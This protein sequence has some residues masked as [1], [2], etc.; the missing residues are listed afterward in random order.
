[1]T[2]QTSRFVSVLALSPLFF[3]CTG[4]H[5]LHHGQTV[6]GVVQ[7]GGQFA[8]SRSV[9]IPS[10]GLTLATAVN[11]NLR[12]WLTAQAAQPV[13]L[14]AR[15]QAETNTS[16]TPPLGQ[17]SLPPRKELIDFFESIREAARENADDPG[18]EDADE[19]RNNFES[20]VDRLATELKGWNNM[21]KAL[22]ESVVADIT[23]KFDA[24][25]KA[26]ES[27]EDEEE[28]KVLEAKLKRILQDDKTDLGVPRETDQQSSQDKQNQ[29]AS[30]SETGRASNAMQ[31]NSAS[32]GGVDQSAVFRDIAVVVTRRNKRRIVAPLWLV[33]R[34]SAGDMLLHDGDR[35]DVVH[36][37]LTEVGSRQK[38]EGNVTFVVEGDS[39]GGPARTE[40]SSYLPQLSKEIQQSGVG[41]ANLVDVMVLKHIG[42][43]GVI[44]EYLI[45]R[46]TDAY[47]PDNTGQ[48]WLDE[49]NLLTGDV[50]QLQNLQLFP[51]VQQGQNELL[52]TSAARIRRDPRADRLF[53]KL[54]VK[55]QKAMSS[56]RQQ[57][58]TVS[59]I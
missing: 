39:G 35:V 10:S 43:T 47:G 14:L 16:E 41:F 18:E 57:L 1:M 23:E 24:L 11:E 28:V 48:G 45:P 20:A 36:F 40:G 53:R 50:I 56:F 38:P 21:P 2:A 33:Q 6:P 7:T 44:E 49:V 22:R 58:Q 55:K 29:S 31:L 34:H 9:P 8:V 52:R 25:A 13:V 12:P 37:H 15:P 3:L 27:E 54:E 42:A 17:Q 5:V 26:Q 51:A 46:H 59:G 4:C 30:S 32:I 19:K